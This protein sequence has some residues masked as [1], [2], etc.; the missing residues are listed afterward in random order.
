MAEGFPSFADLP[1]ADFCNAL[2]A[3]EE[4]A[5]VANERLPT[6]PEELARHYTVR[7]VMDGLQVVKA[8]GKAELPLDV[9]QDGRLVGWWLNVEGSTRM[10][11]GLGYYA[12]VGGKY[13]K[14]NGEMWTGKCCLA[15]KGTEHGRYLSDEKVR[16]LFNS[17][18]PQ[19]KTEPEAPH[20]EEEYLLARTVLFGFVGRNK[21]PIPGIRFVRNP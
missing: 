9:R 17:A 20:T 7:L 13:V 12:N 2:S 5:R 11:E 14:T 19:Y 10:R 1:F 8:A 21:L 16:A 15:L 18:W 6:D 4:A 3:A